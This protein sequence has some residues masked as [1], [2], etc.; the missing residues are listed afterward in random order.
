[1]E[2]VTAFLVIR[3]NIHNFR[4]NSDQAKREHQRSTRDAPE[5]L[6]DIRAWS[7]LIFTHKQR[8]TAENVHCLVTS[9]S[10]G[11][12]RSQIYCCCRRLLVDKVADDNPPLKCRELNKK[13]VIVA[14]QLDGSRKSWRGI[15][16]KPALAN[17]HVLFRKRVTNTGRNCAGGQRLS[18]SQIVSIYCR[19]HAQSQK[20]MPSESC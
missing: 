8:A 15:N 20:S 1:M 2:R 18:S 12:C 14:L 13:T 16:D 19:A 10:R 17:G 9:L 5:C 11:V 6:R 7:E 3:R 4:D